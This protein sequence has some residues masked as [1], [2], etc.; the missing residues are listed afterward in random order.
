MLEL[1]L[2]FA[3]LAED[4]GPLHLLL[5][6]VRRDL[7]FVAVIQK[8]EDAVVFFLFQWIVLVVVA[9][10]AL[11]GDAKDPLS[12]GVH[13]IKHRLHA[14]LFR[15]NAALFVQHGV[16]QEACGHDLVLGRAGEHVTRDLLKDEL[17]VRQ[18]L[19]EC[20]DDPIAVEPH[21]A[22]HVLF[23]AVGISVARRVEPLSTPF[24][25]V[26]HGP[27]E[28]VHLF[29]VGVLTFVGKEGVNFLWGWQ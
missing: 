28:P 25:A 6:G 10:S 24:L 14:E 27:E 7:R 1:R 19:V 11:D 21:V 17:V 3:S 13:A 5:R 18:I 12:D 29:L 15:I 23:K 22:R 8:C 4:F 16:A 9:L 2:K 26:V 20:V